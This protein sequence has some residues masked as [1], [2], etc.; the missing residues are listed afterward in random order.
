MAQ[1]DSRDTAAGSGGTVRSLR[2]TNQSG[3]RANNERLIL[4]L[5]RRD[6][7]LA[8]SD[9]SRLTGLS[10]QT[11]SVIVRG[12]EE[13]GLLA[14]GE[15]QRGRIGQPSIPMTLDPDGVFFIGLKI[16]RRRADLVL[17]D[18]AGAVRMENHLTYPYPLPGALMDFLKKGLDAIE[19][20]LDARQRSRIAGIGIAAPF[21]LWKWRDRL[22]A[23]KA[24][25][26]AWRTFSFTEAIAEI[27][28]L[29]VFIENDASCACSAENVLGRG[30][31]FTSFA[32]FFVGS[33]VGGGVVLNDAM[34]T[35][36]T[37]NAGAFGTLPVSPDRG[38]PRQLIDCASIFVLE[39]MLKKAGIDPSPLWLQPDGWDGFEPHLAE[40]IDATA[41]GLALAAVSV[42]AVIDFEA[43]LIE[44]GFPER[45]KTRIVETARQKLA[46]LDT[47]GIAMPDIRAA[48][49]GANARVLGAASLPLFARFLINHGLHESAVA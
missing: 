45:V 20:L 41:E 49:V 40:W 30:S 44:G 22:G 29:P 36:R 48:A 5:L 10:A 17:M 9:L 43:V 14:R 2:G 38:R 37:G 6:G 25:M 46:G 39:S 35:G 32:Y 13:E 15:P 7:A 1:S 18:F 23:P 21:E 31:E 28:D 34:F 33:F 16:G 24:E 47:Q 11:I 8:K 12:L 19:D 3:M 26:E 4:T 27:S 42:C